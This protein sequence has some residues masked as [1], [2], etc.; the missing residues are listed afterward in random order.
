[1]AAVQVWCSLDPLELERII[2]RRVAERPHGGLL[3]PLLIVVPTRRLAL[4]LK[5]LLAREV[6]AALGVH[7]FTHRGLAA[8][9]LQC[10]LEVPPVVLPRALLE[11]L[12]ESLA[13]G[14]SGEDAEHL[15]RFGGARAALVS[16]LEELREAL[17]KPEDLR[18]KDLARRGAGPLLAR[19]YERYARALDALGRE[20]ATD[21]A[22]AIEAALPHVEGFLR[23]KGI[24]R[25]VHHGA[26][27][28]TG[29]H[30]EL[31]DR[32]ARAAETETLVP[33]EPGLAASRYAQPFLEAL[34]ARGAKIDVVSPAEGSR[35]REW[36]EAIRGLYGPP[37]RSAEARRPDGI[38]LEVHNVQGPEAE[39]ELAALRALAIHD[40]EGVPL[41]EIAIVA[42]SLE[43][44]VPFIEPA[45]EKLG[46]PFSTSAAVPIARDPVVSAFL[47]L[48]EVLARDF[49]R[50]RVIDL[51]ARPCVRFPLETEGGRF[52][53]L[54]DADRW[55]RW[56]RE[57]RI[58]S[59]LESWRELERWV[60][61]PPDIDDVEEASDEE[62]LRRTREAA[63]RSA[64]RL[65]AVLGVL[66]GERKAWDGARTFAEHAAFLRSLARKYL[67]PSPAAEGAAGLA[68]E[69]ER[70]LRVVER[71]G[72]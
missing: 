33:A 46:V 16:G 37:G 1:M 50:G 36:V 11:K 63:K 54:R 19:V 41:E 45:F 20:G 26:Y 55:D 9:C 5:A 69:V 71:A 62:E 35:R 56:S 64:G 15:R 7:V 44:Y 70:V 72:A 40:R 32:I 27:E 8:R 43:P 61:R 30:L 48:V 17:V 57:A 67:A 49:P 38:E 12:V 65:I 6:G 31:L 25:A 58:V 4:H 2:V 66:E 24:R 53:D 13:A 42:R 34:R 68:R 22:G 39:L 60:D 47:A 28:L 21:R 10:A 3:D 51:L 14:E 18:G 59:G 23:R 52:A 29:A